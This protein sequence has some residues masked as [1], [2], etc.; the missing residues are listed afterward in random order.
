MENKVII[1][2]LQEQIDLAAADLA[3]AEINL[4]ETVIAIS[5]GEIP[6]HA[7]SQLVARIEYAKGLSRGLSHARDLLRGE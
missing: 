7:P 1:E 6:E 2:K 4:S 3:L 5:R